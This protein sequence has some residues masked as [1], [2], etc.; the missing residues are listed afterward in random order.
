MAGSVLL[1]FVS[2][3]FLAGGAW[4]WGSE[5]T[6]LGPM[7]W[8]AP[9]VAVLLLGVAGWLYRH[10]WPYAVEIDE[11]DVRV[12]FR[13][14]KIVSTTRSQVVEVQCGGYIYGQ[15]CGLVYRNE[16]GK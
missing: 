11:T 14:H 15:S 2:L 13:P 8:L 6:D 1:V 7:V 16:D 3:F 12:I 9:L 5:R 10:P 4:A